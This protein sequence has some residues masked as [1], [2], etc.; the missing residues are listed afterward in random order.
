MTD[1]LDLPYQDEGARWLAS[2]KHALL[3]DEPGLGKTRQAIMACR[4]LGVLKVRI[5]C[6]A[7]VVDN[8]EREWRRFGAA[9]DRAAMSYNAATKAEPEDVDVLI[10][11]E[12]HYLKTRTAA[13]TK[14]VYGG[15][16]AR[17]K[18]VFVLTGT[19]APNNP[20]EL[21]PMLRALAPELI[22]NKHGK[23]MSYWDF[24]GRYCKTVDKGFGPTIVGGKN[25]QELKAR[26]SPFV[27]RRK[28]ADVLTELPSIRF[29]VLPVDGRAVVSDDQH[30][31]IADALAAGGLERLREIEP[32][33]ASFRRA[34]GLAKVANVVE[35]VK[36]QLD[37]GLE[38][39]VLM[40]YHR[41]VID[42]LYHGLQKALAADEWGVVVTGATPRE[43]R[44]RF[45]DQFQTLAPCR[46]FIGQ[47]TAAGV[48]ITLT[49]ASDLLFVES[50]W[51]P[52]ENEQAAM[53]IHRVGQHKACLVRF[54]YL[55]GSIDDDIQRACARKLE[56]IK[57]LFD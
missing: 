3:A 50:S 45:I 57:Q 48:G 43:H 38:K 47:I 44:Q 32:H 14:A 11:D 2:R 1:V 29:D 23:P 31:K 26:I 8:W 19:P 30:R 27:L 12:G 7:S 28:K 54:A 35:W 33:V 24:V 21:W 25:L 40:A 53:R 15:H 41:D 46:V 34:V 56:T 49:A 36:D 37:S 20:A 6:P 4:R 18:H 9:E 51:V 17:A 55:A 42:G 39:I 52:S 13:R 22:H 10:L 5:I 16:I